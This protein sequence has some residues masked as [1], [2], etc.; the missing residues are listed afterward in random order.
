AG[1]LV[2]LDPA[3]V[4]F[5]EV[6][7]DH[8]TMII[9]SVGESPEAVAAGPAAAHLL[10][11]TIP[12]FTR[13]YRVVLENAGKIDPER[14]EDYIAQDGYLAL[15][16]ALTEKS[17]LQILEIVNASGLRGRGGAGYPAGLKWG[18]V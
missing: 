7:P 10:D 1:P 15:V 2:S 3:G 9:D 13:Q 18:T 5:Q 8:A 17:P 6:S 12:F 11:T 4:M 16:T 14:L